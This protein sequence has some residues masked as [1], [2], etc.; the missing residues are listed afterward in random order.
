VDCEFLWSKAMEK[1]YKE[2]N[3]TAKLSPQAILQQLIQ[4][5]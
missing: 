4:N 1:K 2:L 5:I 3:A